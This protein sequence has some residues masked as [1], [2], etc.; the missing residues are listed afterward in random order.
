M[1]HRFRQV[2]WSNERTSDPVPADRAFAT[3][4]SQVKTWVR[5]NPQSAFVAAIAAGFVVGLL[6]KERK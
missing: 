1:I 4:V 3:F 2:N 6:T 5:D